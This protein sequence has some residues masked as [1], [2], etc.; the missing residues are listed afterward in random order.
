MSI[1]PYS[2]DYHL[3]QGLHSGYPLCCVFNREETGSGGECPE[4][5]EAGRDYEI[6]SCSD[7]IPAC[8]A[9]IE[10][11]TKGVVSRIREK[12][13][14]GYK[15]ISFPNLR[16]KSTLDGVLAALRD[17]GYVFDSEKT[18]GGTVLGVDSEGPP[19]KITYVYRRK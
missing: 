11:V 5:E 19:P 17:N 16:F 14:E 6:H 18:F 1:E 12:A 15:E 3:V 13:E 2:P 7:D 9:Y 8:A 4:C 10:M